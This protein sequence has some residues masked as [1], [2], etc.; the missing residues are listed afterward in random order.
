[1][2]L[3]ALVAASCGAKPSAELAADAAAADA[4]AGG[5]ASDGDGPGVTDKE[6]KVGFVLLQTEKLQKT[7]GFTL[8]PEG[9]R[10]A[11]IQELADEVNAT[12]GIAGRKMVPVI[13]PFEALTDSQA[14]EE[15]LCK[16][17]TQDDQVFAVVLQ[18]QFQST[19]RSCYAQAQTLMLDTTAF[20]L[21]QESFEEYAPYLWQPSY[22]EYGQLNGAMVRDLADGGFFDDAELGVVGI[23]NEQNRRVFDEQ[24]APA[25]DDVGVDPVDVRWIDASN[26]STLQ[27][28]QDQAVLA[29]KDDDVDR[30]LVVGGSRLASFMMATA[31][32]QQ[33]FPRFALSTWDSPDFGIRNYPDSMKGAAGVSVM[34]GFDV[35]DDQY[36]FPAGEAEEQCLEVLGRT[37]DSFPTR[38]NARNQLMWC[39]AAFLLRDAF[40]GSDG[41]VN[42]EAFQEGVA[43]LGEDYD[44]AAVYES[45]FVDAGFTGSIG[46][47]RMLY[48]E[49]CNCMVLE[50]P[51]RS[52]D[53]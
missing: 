21:D 9:D 43:D 6:V 52:F 30:L 50:G 44:S 13:R 26:S 3:T 32:K 38:A 14:T 45:A 33:W 53:G 34:P 7:L 35:A 36:E 49:S 31:Q 42:A 8:P 10:E 37:G 5:V 41:P 24:I 11:Q 4:D 23:D 17:F 40:E 25:L 2:G 16:A 18:G 1:L 20:P 22:P 48:E 51:T 19:V 39:D 15:K 12:G 47:R 28:G 29:F 27:T 46:F